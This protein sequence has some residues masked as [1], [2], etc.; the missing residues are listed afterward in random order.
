MRRREG[1]TMAASKVLCFPIGKGRMYGDLMA[2][3]LFA[4]TVATL[5]AQFGR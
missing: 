3:A 4:A 1:A 5:V 2:L